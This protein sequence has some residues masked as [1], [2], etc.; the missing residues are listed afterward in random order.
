MTDIDSDKAALR[1][2]AMTRRTQAADAQPDAGLL[3]VGHVLAHAADFGLDG[4]PKTV[5]AFWP[6][7]AE[8][9]TRPLLEAMTAA[10]HATALPIVAAKATPLVFRRW[11]AGDD[12][13]DGGFGTSIP[14]PAAPEV[15]PDV[16]FV[17]L[18]AFDGAGYRLGYGGGFYDRTLEKLRAEGPVLAVGVA[19][20]AQR[21]ETVPRDPYDQRLDWIVTEEGAVHFA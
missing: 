20:S 9:D 6:M 16:L 12:L 21:V 10:G 19:F 13:V 4:A 5:S 8:I 1:A 3:L 17:P 11:R 7:G 15:R 14:A 18:L 2:E